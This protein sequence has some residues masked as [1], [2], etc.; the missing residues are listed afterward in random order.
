MERFIF[1][2]FFC[3]TTF[4]SSSLNAQDK[5]PYDYVDPFIGTGGHG[6]TY[7]G[8][9]L[10]FG[11][12]Q[13]S[14]D[15]RLTGWD[16][17]SGFHISDSLV[18]GFSHTHLS[19]T[20]VSDYGDLLLMP[21]TGD[22]HFN[23]GADGEEGYRNAYLDDKGVAEPGYYSVRL[24]EPRID[25]ELA[26]TKRTG[27]HK[28][29]FDDTD[30]AHI[31]IDLEHRD[32]VIDSGLRR[33]NSRELEGYRISNAWAKEQHFYF[34]IRSSVPFKE[35]KWLNDQSADS[36]GFRRGQNVKAAGII[37]FEGQKKEIRLQVGISA[38]SMDGARANLNAEQQTGDSF[39]SVHQRARKSWDDALEKITV[40]GQN[41]S[42]LV[43]FYTAMY[44]SMLCPNLFTDA[45]KKYRGLDNDIHNAFGYEQYTVFSL[46]DTY[47]ATH[48]L[49]TIIEQE[50]TRHFINSFLS[51]YREG[52]ILP[53]WELSGNYTG[54]MIGYHSIPVIVDAYRKGI[55]KFDHKE[56]LDA[57]VHSARQEHLGLEGYQKMGFI[58]SDDESE[59]VSKTLEYAYDDWCIAMFA[60]DLGEDRIYEEF[61]KRA[62][63]YKNIFDP[64]TGFMRAKL[65]HT[66]V[67]PFAPEEV[68]FHFTE[69]NSW[70]YS[71]SVPQD[72][73][74]WI[75]CLGGKDVLD[76]KLDA[77]FTAESETSGR[78][79][80]DITGLIGQYAHGNEPSHHIAY[81]YNYINK[82]W[83]SQKMVRRILKEMYSDQ[84]DGLSGNEDCG[85]MSSWYVF[86]ALGF[87]PVTP[88]SDIYAIGSPLFDKAKIRLENGKTFEIIAKDQS[89]ENTF[90]QSAK[91]NGKKLER[92]YLK[93]EEIMAGGKLV[94]AMGNSPDSGWATEDANV[95]VSIIEEHLIVPVPYFKGNR[96]FDGQQEVS[97]HSLSTIGKV[98]CTRNFMDG[99][100]K[101]RLTYESPFLI[102]Q[103]MELSATV[104]EDG[105]ASS[106]YAV[107]E[108]T[109]IEQNKKIELK[110]QY[111]SQ[112]AAGGD[113][114]LIDYQKGALDF[115]TGSWQ[116]YEEVDLDVVIDLG[117]SQVISQVSTTFLQDQ[118]SWIFLPH[119]VVY[120]I[121]EDG[122]EFKEM[123]RLK[124]DI[125]PLQDGSLIEAFEVE[126]IQ[127][128]RYIRVFADNRGFC[129][130]EHKGAGGKSWIFVDEIEIE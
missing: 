119:E 58:S 20:G 106:K 38:V 114:A 54:C 7:P 126:S 79:Q 33:I 127:Y 9:S 19:G 6:H 69:A 90:I 109:K 93:H 83:K 92:S 80:V 72:I 123:G 34:V 118:N 88:G 45:D 71:F 59:S 98:Y 81:L 50:R 26:V 74:G 14:P 87:Y 105:F 44:H 112:Y 104:F 53:I 96:V 102:D 42:E 60:N 121:S 10:P 128:G 85:Q 27:M 116:G 32:Q 86:S 31:I 107:A 97:I 124:T 122:I 46:W 48:P 95:P 94:F 91:L 1:Y 70:Q 76:E 29:T 30:N 117:E 57:M 28:Y 68:N 49:F 67:E 41:H 62:Q 115:R 103:T 73:S 47:R 100:K 23:N 36:T 12:I 15:T 21:Q 77:L 61:M 2:L 125:D 39:D 4:A 99:S 35:W 52:G 64:E 108:F 110:T 78:E 65:N 16:G 101:K 63:S 24:R 89:P 22:I 3:C 120:E 56:A 17:C 113:Q 11:M 130:A 129:P 111:A 25:V 40:E 82:P 43:T 5:Q 66:F 55:T 8:A 75:E 18:Y 84:P 37:D 51:Q 13:L